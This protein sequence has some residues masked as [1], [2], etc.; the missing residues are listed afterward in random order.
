VTTTLGAITR[1]Q[2]E[3]QRVFGEV[4]AGHLLIDDSV[5]RNPDWTFAGAHL[6]IRI[7][8]AVR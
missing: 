1:A 4:L 8:P 6:R 2:N 7:Q 3:G 5:Y